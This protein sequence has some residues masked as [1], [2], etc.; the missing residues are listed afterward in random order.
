[1]MPYLSA[2]GLGVMTFFYR[3]SDKNVLDFSLF[4]GNVCVGLSCFQGF[5][6]D[7]S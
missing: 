7:F 1:M 3:T 4:C 2:L 6:L 5:G